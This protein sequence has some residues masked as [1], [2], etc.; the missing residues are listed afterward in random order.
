MIFFS[1]IDFFFEKNITF[2]I[3]TH[4]NILYISILKQ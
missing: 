1:L 3:S 4:N 2:N